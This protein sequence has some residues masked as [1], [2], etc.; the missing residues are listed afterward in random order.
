[1]VYAIFEELESSVPL[2]QLLPSVA[3]GRCAAYLPQNVDSLHG[4]EL[5]QSLQIALAIHSKARVVLQCWVLLIL[6]RR[7]G[8]S[9]E[10]DALY[11][12]LQLTPVNPQEKMRYRRGAMLLCHLLV[13]RDTAESGSSSLLDRYL[14]DFYFSWSSAVNERDDAFYLRG[15][16]VVSWVRQAL[17]WLDQNGSKMTAVRWMELNRSTSTSAAV[18]LPVPSFL[19]P[20]PLAPLDSLDTL[21][22]ASVS[23]E[24]AAP[25]PLAHRTRSQG[26]D[27]IP[28]TTE[29]AAAAA[30]AAPPAWST[31]LQRIASSPPSHKKRKKRRRADIFSERTEIKSLRKAVERW[32]K[33]LRQQL[34]DAALTNNQEKILRVV[35]ELSAPPLPRKAVQRTRERRIADQDNTPQEDDGS[36]EGTSSTSADPRS[37]SACS[38]TS[39]GSDSGSSNNTTL[40]EPKE[41][42]VCAEEPARMEQVWNVSCGHGFCGVCM[43]ARLSQRERKGMGCRENVT[44]VVDSDGTRFQHYEWTLWWKQSQRV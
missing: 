4:D 24:Q 16:S 29:A 27:R 18:V 31:V 20:P 19:L 22:S 40:Q 5:V 6:R 3:F 7:A 17:E 42:A 2:A 38:S 11:D 21:V 37:T 12:R 43:Y 9:H 30:A 28:P 15:D 41:C 26:S 1:M 44:Q 36:N 8:M 32:A 25:P 13:E 34:L 33:R 14:A 35:D 10:K 39:T 23:V